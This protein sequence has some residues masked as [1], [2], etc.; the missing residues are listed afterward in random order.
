MEETYKDISGYEGIYQISDNGNVKSLSFNNSGKEKVLK[1]G[2]NDGYLTVMLYKNG[3]RKNCLVHRLI[4]NE[5][6]PNPNHK[7]Q[8]NH[9][10]GNKKNN[11]VKNLEW[12]SVSENQ[13]HRFKI[14]GY[15][16][17]NFGKL[18]ENNSYS[19]K[20]DQYSKKGGFIKTWGSMMD[21]KR[22]LGISNINIGRCCRGEIM[23]AG[24]YVWK[25]LER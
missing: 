1:F 3:K 23:S 19:I 22:E 15:K 8:I 24:G 7:P 21:V 20:V 6:I 9:I 14:L 5:F 12:V 4:G 10:D 25:Y 18:G 16:G 17:P 11:R 13:T 2:L